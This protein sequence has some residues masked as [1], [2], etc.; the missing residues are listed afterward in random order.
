MFLWVI[1][2]WLKAVFLQGEFYIR[3]SLFKECGVGLCGTS[4]LYFGLKN[5][6]VKRCVLRVCLYLEFES[7]NVYINVLGLWIEIDSLKK[8]TKNKTKK[9]KRERECRDLV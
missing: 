9:E 4:F 2:L 5:A 1:L 8:K 3:R 6:R 7:V